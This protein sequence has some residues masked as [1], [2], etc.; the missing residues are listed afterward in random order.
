MS[1]TEESIPES[2]SSEVRSIVLRI[3]GEHFFCETIDVPRNLDPDAVSAFADQA[4]GEERLSPFPLEQ[5][6]WGYYASLEHGRMLLLAT[7]SAKL[8]QLGWQNLEVF[9]R[10]FPSFISFFGKEF[11][12]ST[13]CL[14]RHDETLMGVSFDENCPVPAQVFSL[15]LTE[16]EEE[17]NRCDETRGK[18]LALFD[19]ERYEI[20]PDILVTGD[21]HRSN[22]GFF[23]FDHHRVDADLEDPP[24]ET[25]TLH[26][27]ELWTCDLR[28]SDFK[29]AEQAR[30]EWVRRRWM[31]FLGW[32]VGIAALVV[33]FVGSK[34][35]EKK[36]EERAFD[37]QVMAEQVPLVE[38]SRKLLEKLRQNKLGGIDPFGA[39]GR[40]ASQRGGQGDQPHVWFTG[41]HFASRNEIILEGQGRNVEAVNNFIKGMEDDGVGN[42]QMDKSGDKK[43]KINSSL[44]KTSFTIELLLLEE[45]NIEEAS[46]SLPEMPEPPPGG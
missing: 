6:A 2:S 14:L 43:R 34:V 35:F 45:K 25:V 19:L 1:E 27:D 12:R 13:I 31:A 46:A 8:R 5:E 4:M 20:D 33:A 32:G 23:H 40:L 42:V 7:S 26:A 41:A 18:L 29:Q 24:L 9:R 38:E 3:P 30:R 28:S 44:G 39:L 11:E 17:E 16:Q 22:D 37:A 15:P 10:V 21:V 36:A